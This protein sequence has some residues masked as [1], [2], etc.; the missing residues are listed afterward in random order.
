MT[1][2]YFLSFLY[3]ERF[4]A[5]AKETG[6]EIFHVLS[7]QLPGQMSFF[8]SGALLYYFFDFFQK[9]AGRLFA[10]AVAV[11][12]LA[13]YFHLPMFIPLSMGVMVIYAAYGL[14]YL[15]NMGKF[16]DFSYGV[17]IGHFPL[18]Q[19]LISMKLFNNPYTG[20]MFSC[21]LAFSAAFLS[22]HLVEKPFLKLFSHYRIASGSS[23]FA[24]IPGIRLR[25]A[26]QRSRPT[27]S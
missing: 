5:L 19:F 15:G 20:L 25:R 8:I 12:I 22:W 23:V 14:I 7:R 4:N 11:Y 27:R 16:G 13:R 6:R 17:Y 9:Y 21:A 10:A 26:A 1:L 18:L 24:G 2:I 3:L